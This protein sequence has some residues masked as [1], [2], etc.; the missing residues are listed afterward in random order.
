MSVSVPGVMLGTAAYRS[1]EQAKG[2]TA[3][4]R[5]DIWAFG[6]V[7]YEMLTGRMAFSGETASETMAAVMMR[8]P[9][10]NALPTNVPAR[11][12]DLLRRCLVKDPRNRLR[13][14]GDARLAVE[15]LIAHPD[16]GKNDFVSGASL[17]PRRVRE[18]LAWSTAVGALLVAGSVLWHSAYFRPPSKSDIGPVR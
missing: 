10:W 2:R 15:E 4:K 11:L 16:A 7:L 13:D 3:D 6:V 1:P 14:I 5:A 18:W 8:D 17:Q 12:R 9:D